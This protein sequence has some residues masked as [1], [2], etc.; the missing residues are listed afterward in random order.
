MQRSLRYLDY[1]SVRPKSAGTV[2]E[3]LHQNG[4]NTAWYG[5]YYNVPDWHGR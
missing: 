4:C 5:K 2:A 1:D 3:I